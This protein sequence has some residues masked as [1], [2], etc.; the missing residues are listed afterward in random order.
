[1]SQG[2]IHLGELRKIPDYCSGFAAPLFDLSAWLGRSIPGAFT[3]L[4]MS[5][6][7]PYSESELRADQEQILTEK[8]CVNAEDPGKCVKEALAYSDRTAANIDRNP[9]SRDDPTGDPRVCDAEAMVN[10]PIL[11]SYIGTGLFCPVSG[12]GVMVYGGIALGLFIFL[13]VISR[14][15]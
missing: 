9:P 7:T 5:P 8:T 3:T 11:T 15:R 6:C 14:R 4:P 10:W 2:M 12:S 1:M 13:K